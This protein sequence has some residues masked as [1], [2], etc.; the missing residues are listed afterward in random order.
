M[1]GDDDERASLVNPVKDLLKLAAMLDIVPQRA[2]MEQ[3]RQPDDFDD[4]R[5]KMPV[6]VLDQ[7]CACGRG[8]LREGER[9]VFQRDL[10]VAAVEAAH[11][12]RQWID[13]GKR[14]V[15]RQRLHDANADTDEQVN[16]AIQGTRALAH[17]VAHGD[18]G[19]DC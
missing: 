15:P 8:E 2:A 18:H 1:P 13:K 9:Q 19:I 17:G 12:P 16:C 7:R 5:R 10:A 11:Q 6:A 4:H 3:A 14:G